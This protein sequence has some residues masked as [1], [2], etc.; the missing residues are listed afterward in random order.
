MPER[1]I[2]PLTETVG[3]AAH[4]LTGAATDDDPL[5]ELVGAAR[6][7]L[8]GE[9][10]HGTHEF[11][12]ERAQLTK[13]LITEIGFT[14]V[15]VEA[16][17]PDAYRVNHYVR[18]C[19]PPDATADEALSGF[20]RFPT[21]MWRNTVV[22]DFV[23]WLRTYN[24]AL[25]ASGA[26]VGF[27]GLDLYSLFA[28]I[29][30]VIGYLDHVDPAAARRARERYACFEHAG[31]EAENYGV[32]TAAG[33]VE[34]CEEE[35][36]QQLVDLQ[37]HAHEYARRD[38]RV[39]ED[40][41][42]FAEQNARLVKNAEAYYRAMFRGR[43]SSWNLRDRHMAETLDALVAHLDRHGGP[44]KVVVWAHNSHV[45]DARATELGEHGELN[46][47][48]LVRERYGREAVLVGFTTYSGTVTAASDWGGAAERKQVRPG[49]SGSYEAL[50]HATGLP[51]FFVSMRDERLAAAAREP[52]LERA[53]GVIY[54]PETEHVSHY[55]YARMAEQF[56]VVV[57]CDETRAVE[58]LE[59]TS[60]WEAGEVPE[61]FPFGV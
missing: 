33:L 31:R 43:V 15:A 29:E 51:R 61:T 47:G 59:R 56:D 45:G 36:V 48:Q 12:H 8:I 39:A 10:S 2:T 18:G 42:F 28:S 49:L 44:T 50:F 7:V 26:Q 9:A 37:R 22:R 6:I 60:L 16:D 24:A 23:Q 54:R 34:P 40:D 46:V 52:R 19:L 30:A 11:Y 58:P 55:F 20:R 21:W 57:H 35:V 17:W 4:P 38:G 14:A 3:M 53:I 32:A 41:F 13:R 27:Y 1:A 5:M 25:P